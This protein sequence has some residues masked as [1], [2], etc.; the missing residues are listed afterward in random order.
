MGIYIHMVAQCA[1]HARTLAACCLVFLALGIL[2]PFKLHAQPG[3][4]SKGR[5]FYLAFPPNDRSQSSQP[6][7]AIHITADV[8]T[9]GIVYATTR[10]GTTNQFPFA[11][12]RPNELVSVRLPNYA[13][14]ELQGASMGGR[15]VDR[16]SPASIVVRSDADVTVYASSRE[17]LSTDAWLV[18][19][20]DALGTTHR[21]V[22]YASDV[23][24]N[25]F[26]FSTL[27]PSQFVLVATRDSTI[28]RLDFPVNRT[29]V[30]TGSSRSIRLDS[31][32]VYMT[33]AFVSTSRRNDDL[34]GTL[35]QSN[36]PIAVLGAH[37]RAQVPVFNTNAS[38]D[39][40]VEQLPAVD[41]WG[42]NFL[43]PML[44]FAAG[45]VPPSDNDRALVRVVAHFNQ[46][47]ISIDGQP[48]TT[49]SAG[50]AYT[51]RL[52]RGVVI[53]SSQP[54]LVAIIDRSASRGVF[55]SGAIGD[56]S[57]MVVPPLEQYLNAYTCI[58]IEPSDNSLTFD[59]HFFV[60]SGT[61]AALTS[62]RVDNQPVTDIFPFA[63]PSFSYAVVRVPAGTH[64]LRSTEP[65]GV[66]AI[67]YGSA[68][69]YGYTGG[70]AFN[71][72]RTPTVY[73]RLSDVKGLPGDQRSIALT[74]D[75]IT[76]AAD[77]FSARP[78]Q[79]LGTVAY[80]TSLFVL[81]DGDNATISQTQA[82]L[83]ISIV[84][85][86]TILDGDTLALFDGTITLG[87]TVQDSSYLDAMSIVIDPQIDVTPTIVTTAGMISLDSVCLENGPRL[88]NP[89]VVARPPVIV[90]KGAVA[91]ATA[92]SND[93]PISVIVSDVLGRT[94]S[95]TSGVGSVTTSVPGSGMFFIRAFSGNRATTL[96]VLVP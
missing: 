55:P 40:L 85:P 23:I 46:T 52:E 78:R 24:A 16:I 5:E 4:D 6:E 94:C 33:Q 64:T 22:T 36:F 73:L 65:F 17:L 74:V 62:L 70:M 27:Y 68:E 75:S 44:P 58:S 14:Y 59:E 9:S 35:I 82:S 1:G 28:V 84:L 2:R 31:G 8:P 89:L 47:V 88:F 91:H 92:P 25:A 45:V 86:D 19:P 41:R 37:E 81:D 48:V 7:L 96:S 30:Q 39:L 42:Q 95:A 29:S 69:S 18:L 90:W 38:R 60:V 15:D 63:D 43:V 54:V 87:N 50:S 71:R 12:T 11:I 10:F 20:V 3:S 26:G 83:P 80:N 61:R 49:L 77:F 66:L 13:L 93:A 56:P 34:T 32:D 53:T 79:L 67:G 21:V 57:L 51:A 76:F 72:L